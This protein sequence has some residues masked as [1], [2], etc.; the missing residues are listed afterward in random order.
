MNSA[1][2]SQ[3]VKDAID[4]PRLTIDDLSELYG[5]SPHSLLKYRLGQRSPHRKNLENISEGL[6]MFARQLLFLREQIEKE[7]QDDGE[8]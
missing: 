8:S 2:K 4:K 6:R 3:I 5:I 7:L 1:Q